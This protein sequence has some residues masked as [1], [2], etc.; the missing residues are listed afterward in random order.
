MRTNETL[1]A[2]TSKVHYQSGEDIMVILCHHPHSLGLQGD[3]DRRRERKRYEWM[4]KVA[5]S[6]VSES[7]VES[8][9]T[10]LNTKALI[11][12]DK[13]KAGFNG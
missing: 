8:E 4:E 5:I 9:Q 10:M 3:G 11:S 1:F 2:L 6:V 7:A 13:K 12:K